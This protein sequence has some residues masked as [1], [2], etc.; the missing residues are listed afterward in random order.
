MLEQEW[1]KEERRRAE[2][3]R[4]ARFTGGG[5]A[6]IST[7]VRSAVSSEGVGGGGA[8]HDGVGRAK[9]NVKRDFFGRAVAA[10]VVEGESEEVRRVR[11]EKAKE[12]GKVWV[13]YHEGFSNAVRK[14]L[15]LKELM[16]DL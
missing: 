6:D 5:N 3:A 8:K 9:T 2:K 14:P 11:E 1:G 4:Q 7:A 15:T 12:E 10:K 13:S 16:K